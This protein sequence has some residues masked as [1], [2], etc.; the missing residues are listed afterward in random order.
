MLKI[1]VLSDTHSFLNKN[2]PDFFSSC[3]EIWHAGDI[4]DIIVSDNLSKLKKFRAVHGNIDNYIIRNVFPKY[5]FFNC[6]DLKV[7]M[8]HIGG[9]PGKYSPEA[10]ELILKYKPEIFV[11]GHSHILK[12]I[13][14]KKNKLLYINPGASGNTGFHNFITAVK[15]TISGK[16]ISDMEILELKRNGLP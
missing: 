7:L 2:I 6:E 8:M 1:G 15:F 11:A 12:I 3:D 10:K 9:Y 14:D 4:G 16:N 5:Q 13:Y